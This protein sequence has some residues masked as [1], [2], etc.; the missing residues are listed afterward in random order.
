MHIDIK[1][2]LRE[3]GLRPSKGLGQN[4]LQDGDVAERIVDFAGLKK[5][6]RVLEIGPGLGVLTDFILKKTEKLILVERD[7]TL[8]SYLEG[9]YS[10][11]DIKIMN[12]DVL[13]VDL[14]RFDKVIS[15]LPYN[16][17]SPLTFKILKNDFEMAVL[18]YQKEFAERMSADP[19]DKNYSRLSVMTSIYAEIEELFDIPRDRFFPSPDVTSTV[20]RLEPASPSF[21]IKNQKF[22]ESVVREMFN[23]RRKKIKNS[24]E[25]GLDL[26]LDS[27]PYGDKRVGKLSPEQINEIVNHLLEHRDD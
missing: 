19:G 21:E 3:I 15:N 17:S 6:D 14:P 8:A 13:E 25:T 18:T 16:I 23:Y 10:D 1:R 2:R 11:R 26:K 24:I 5:K 27:I 7:K 20:V 12:K 4:F 9:R 22:F